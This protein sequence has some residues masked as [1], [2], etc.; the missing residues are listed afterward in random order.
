MISEDPFSNQ[1]SNLVGYAQVLGARGDFYWIGYSYDTDGTLQDAT[2]QAVESS[3][4]LL[5]AGSYGT[6]QPVSPGAGVCIAIGG[7]DGLLYR[8]ICS[9]L[10]PSFCHYRI[11]GE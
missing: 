11:E 2:G 3:S 10:L 9:E 8:T 7:E 5:R 6:D 4:V 1:F